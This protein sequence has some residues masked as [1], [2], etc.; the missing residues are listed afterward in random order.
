MFSTDFYRAIADERE[1]QVTEHVR[2]RN[3]IRPHRA[4]T[5]PRV[6]PLASLRGRTRR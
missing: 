1:R 5:A 4:A 3:L 6:G 2:V